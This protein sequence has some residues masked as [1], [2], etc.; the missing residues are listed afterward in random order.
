MITRCS[1]LRMPSGAEAAQLRRGRPEGPSFSSNDKIMGFRA[2][3]NGIARRT[4]LSFSTVAVA[5]LLFLRQLLRFLNLDLDL[6]R[7]TRVVL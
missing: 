6:R 2:P 7:T 3:A 5:C 4:S 1:W